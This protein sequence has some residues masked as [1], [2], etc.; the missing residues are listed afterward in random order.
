MEDL[1]L[2]LAIIGVVTGCLGTSLALIDLIWR[3]FRRKPRLKITDLMVSLDFSK[4]EGQIHARISFM[5]E[6]TGNMD[7]FLTTINAVFG[8]KVEAINSNRKI[9]AN[10][11]IRVPETA[12]SYIEFAFPKYVDTGQVL[13]QRFFDNKV[14]LKMTLY[15]KFGIIR[16][17]I[18][19]P[20]TAKWEKLKKKH[21]KWL[22]IY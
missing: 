15:H 2:T 13:P 16:K 10:S 5:I 4:K 6:N 17:V 11:S 12:E 22:N 1:T 21:R 3:L 8:P 20:P 14:V 7:T 9:E 19:I 18:A